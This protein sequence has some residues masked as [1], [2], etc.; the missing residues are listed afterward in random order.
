MI[1]ASTLRAPLLREA[2]RMLAGNR[3]YNFHRRPDFILIPDGCLWN[4][5]RQ[6]VLCPVLGADSAGDTASE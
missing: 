6:I 1:S 2:G 4:A 3:T 5:M